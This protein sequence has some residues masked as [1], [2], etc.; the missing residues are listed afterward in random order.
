MSRKI[1][2]EFVGGGA[3]WDEETCGMQKDYLSF[4][5]TFN[6]FVGMSCSEIEYAAATQGGR[7]LSM[8]CSKAIGRTDFREYNTIVVPYW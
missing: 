3:C 5:N 1:M 2:I 8:L 7:S 6:S 4:P